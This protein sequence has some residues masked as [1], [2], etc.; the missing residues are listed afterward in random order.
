MLAAQAS[1]ALPARY[2][3]LGLEFATTSK[4]LTFATGFCRRKIW[5]STTF[6]V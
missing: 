3:G 4:K 5:E 6:M 1:T 2:Q